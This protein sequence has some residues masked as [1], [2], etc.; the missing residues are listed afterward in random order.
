METLKKGLD[1]IQRV[2][3]KYGMKK[4]E[5]VDDEKVLKLT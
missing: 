4:P 5:H 1:A 2:L 3:D